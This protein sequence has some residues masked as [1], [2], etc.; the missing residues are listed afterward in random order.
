L[1][2]EL[3]VAFTCGRCGADVVYEN[4]VAWEIAQ[5]FETI[6]IGLSRMRIFPVIF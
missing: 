1:Q 6:R 4:P 5:H 2:T 3:E